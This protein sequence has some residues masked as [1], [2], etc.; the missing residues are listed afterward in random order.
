MSPGR[1]LGMKS[2]TFPMREAPINKN[3]RGT[4]GRKSQGAPKPS[5]S[6]GR[7]ERGGAWEIARSDSMARL[8]ES[9]RSACR[10]PPLAAAGFGP[11]HPSGLP[12]PFRTLGRYKYP[13]ELKRFAGDRGRTQFA[14]VVWRRGKRAEDVAGE[15]LPCEATFLFLVNFRSQKLSNPLPFKHI[16]NRRILIA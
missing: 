14:T 15:V 6:S 2:P 12:S 8:C 9:R 16:G 13:E 7:N 5:V 11:L 10:F 1:G 3:L 4:E